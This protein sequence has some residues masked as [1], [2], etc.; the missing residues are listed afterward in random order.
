[1]TQRGSS[2][3]TERQAETGRETKR[4]SQ[5]VQVQADAV[6]VSQACKPVPPQI[7]REQGSVL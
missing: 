6:D 7:L 4:E 3:E 5:K 2:R 1:M